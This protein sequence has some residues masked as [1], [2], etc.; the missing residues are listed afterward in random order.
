MANKKRVAFYES[1][2]GLEIYDLLTAMAA[3]EDFN[4]Q[5]GY[6]AD[7]VKYPDN[8]IPFVEKHMVYLSLHPNVEPRGYVSNLRLMTRIR[9]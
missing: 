6:A 9:R 7:S 1:E 8:R 2:E 3:D 5:A 4:T